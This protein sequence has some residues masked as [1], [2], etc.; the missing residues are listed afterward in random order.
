M[1]NLKN[2]L[3]AGSLALVFAACRKTEDLNVQQPV[4]LGG[5]VTASTA[6]DKWIMDSLTIPYNISA[7]YKWDP[8]NASLYKTLTP[9]DESRII[10]LFSALRRTWINPYNDETG[11][12]LFIKKYS[13]KQLVLLGS[14]EYDY[15][16]VTLGQAE[17]GNNI[18]FFD[19]NQNFDKNPVT[20]LKRV[21]HTAHH[22]FAHILHQTVMYPIDFRGTSS[23]LGFPGYTATWFN[24][25]DATALGYGYVTSYAMSG[26][27]D[28]FVETVSIMLTE[29]KGRFD[30]IKASTNATARQALQQKEDFVVSYYQKVWNIDFYSL[31]RRVQAAMNALFPQIVSDN[32]GF[33]KTYTRAS[34]DPTNTMLLPQPAAFTAL[35]NSVK[36]NVATSTTGTYN[37]TMDSMAVITNSATTA[38]VRVYVHQG[39][40]G[41]AA[42]NCD[43][44]FNVTKDA[45]GL[46]SYT[47]AAANGNGSLIKTAVQ[48]LLNYFSGSKFSIDWYADPS[49]SLYPRL[50]FTPQSTPGTYFVARLLP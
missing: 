41:T 30:E 31:Q 45:A 1:K 13:P 7:L 48:P 21:I 10:P 29:G 15:Y 20:S 32:Y 16:S 49:V 8:W 40:A 12:P 3:F 27:D 37:L 39:A 46:Y 50:K 22:E 18:V 4:G 43:Y 5:E 34:V 17:G 9:P 25:S 26:P 36:S 11:S 44:T 47:Y 38:I 19:V 35:Y 28:D 42:F 33:G 14:V 24:I 2:I 23:K 6:I